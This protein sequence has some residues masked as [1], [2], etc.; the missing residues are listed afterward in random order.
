MVLKEEI[1]GI[2]RYNQR[3]ALLLISRERQMSHVMLQ[4]DGNYSHLSGFLKILFAN[5]LQNKNCSFSATQSVR[6][7]IIHTVW[8]METKHVSC[9]YM[10]SY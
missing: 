7:G 3:E 2:S 9:I 6:L 4:L 1:L 10:H 8:T 5:R